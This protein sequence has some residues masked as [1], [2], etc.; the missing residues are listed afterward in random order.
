MK[1]E[2]AFLVPTLVTYAALG[3]E[4]ARLGWSE[5]MLAKLERVRHRGV[6]AIALA[7]AEGVPVV[8]GTDLLGHMHGR[9]NEEFA[10]RLP[11]QSPAEILQ[12]ATAVAARLLRAEGQVGTLAAGALADVLLVDGD[13][14]QSVAM[15]ADPATGIRL[16]MQGGRIVRSSLA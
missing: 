13:P 14:T 12:G 15:W 11:V 3:D 6:E 7:R 8:F 2:G 1:E 5:S 10:L 4:G 9:Q 16:L